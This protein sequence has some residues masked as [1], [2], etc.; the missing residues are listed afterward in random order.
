MKE[1]IFIS[2]NAKSGTTLVQS[3]LDGHPSLS[4][5]PIELKFFKFARLPSLPPGNMPPPEYPEWK[6]PIPRGEW[7][8]RKVK[9][10]ILEHSDIKSL[11][12]GNSIS[13]NV[14][15]PN[16]L[17][18][19]EEFERSFLKSKCNSQKDIYVYL[20]T[21]LIESISGRAQNGTVVVKNPHLEEY[22]QELKSWFPEA[23]FIHVLRNPYANIYSL[24][25]G[26]RSTPRLRNNF[27]RPT[28]KSYYFME[29]NL[30]YVDEYEVFRF[31][32]V[33][34]NTERTVEKLAH[35]IGV[36]PHSTLLRPTIL[37][38][39]WGGNSRTTEEEFDGIDPR[40]VDSFRANISSIDIALVNRFFSTL[41]EKYNYEKLP[42]PSLKKWLPSGLESPFAYVEN[43]YLL[44]DTVL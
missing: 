40:P 11:V 2:G 1:V 44:F 4:V 22:A 34:L 38:K 18:D 20:I 15:I 19:R 26:R 25:K 8:L 43:R 42:T 33:V 36:E 23:K 41:M 32:D 27:Y 5:L 17:L 31:E 16:K 30:R 37:G 13:R 35:H 39:P 9:E 29:R 14:N 21:S 3:L 10:E 12:D 24:R 6:T 7:D 28:A